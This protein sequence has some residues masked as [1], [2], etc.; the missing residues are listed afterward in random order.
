MLKKL[1]TYKI[2]IVIISLFFLTLLIIIF[3]LWHD[4]FE[5]LK[6]NEMELQTGTDI[7]S[8]IETASRFDFSMLTETE[9][10]WLS[11]HPVIT[12]ASDPDWPPVEFTDE[13]GSNSGISYDYAKIIE[14][15]LNIEFRFINNLSWQESY[16]LLKN[17]K[18]DMTTSVAV[19]PDRTRFWTFTKPYLEIPIVV[20]T[21]KDVSYIGNMRELNGKKIAVVDGYAAEEWISSDYPGIQIVKVRNVEEGMRLV[22]ENAVIGFVDNM[23][24][25]GYYLSKLKMSNLKV[26]GTTP[27]V[28]A[29]CMA[30]RND[31]PEFAAII[32]KVLDSITE[33]GRN[34]IYGRW[35][36]VHFE[37]G[38]NYKV[39]WR[40]VAVFILILAGFLFW[41]QKL[42]GE[43]GMRKRIEAD[44]R[45][46]KIKLSNVIEGTNAGTWEWDLLTGELDVNDYWAEVIGYSLKD[47]M[48]VTDIKWKNFFHPEDLELSEKKLTQVFRHELELYDIEC[49]MK[50]SNGDYIWVHIKGKVIEWD[51][52]SKPLLMAG[53]QIDITGRKLSEENIRSLL[54]EKE[55]LLREVHHRIKNNM[56]T[57]KGLLSLQISAEK[58]SEAADSLKDAENRVQSMIMLYERL[59]VTE[60]YRELP[61][62]DYLDSLIFEIISGYPGS[63]KIKIENHIENFVLNLNVLTPLGIIINEL[64]TNIMKYAFRNM[65]NGI[66]KTYARLDGSKLFLS[67]HDN[68]L[69][70]PDEIELKKSS[71]FGL[72]LV[73]MLV[74]QLGGVVNIERSNGTIINMEFQIGK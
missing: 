5:S 34:S 47:L 26:A 58:N 38:F 31:W 10:K 50:H 17:H 8:L 7:E 64:I 21:S 61:V 72:T 33:S 52:D 22:E 42:S 71:G 40:S 32:Q 24:V 25:M 39:L 12:V 36:P 18:I 49:R 74:E 29:Q 9:K 43:I 3:L 51:Q 1:I 19:T 44:L 6:R 53:T 23:L 65:E 4:S 2:N 55:L 68:G 37:F 30:V 67:I 59:Y 60:N 57:I 20:V 14:Q 63:R 69:G 45:K 41:I 66:I 54:S 35:V 70:I 11:E 28:N 62:K 73:G 15:Q 48:P 56:N 46:S 16:R 13:H 27:Y